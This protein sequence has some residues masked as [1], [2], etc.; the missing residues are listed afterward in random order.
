M[1][2]SV[3][4][5]R[6]FAAPV[7]PWPEHD[8]LGRPA[9]EAHR[10]RV[11]EVVLAVQVPLDQRQLLGHAERLAGRQDGDLGHRVGVLGEGGDQGVA[12]LVDRDG[13]LLLGQQDV[14]ALPPAEQDPVP[15]RVEVR[16]A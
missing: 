12:G 3:A 15:G 14:G 6:S 5:A 8:Q 11:G 13:V 1:A 16:G 7:E 2:S 9:A 10:Q 4:P